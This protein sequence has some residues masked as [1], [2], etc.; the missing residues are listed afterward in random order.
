MTVDYDGELVNRIRDGDLLVRADPER[1]DELLTAKGT[2]QAE[3]GDGRVMNKG[4][5]AV[6]EEAIASDENFDFWI[7]V[8]LEY[9]DK[10]TGALSRGRKQKGAR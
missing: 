4:W 7:G 2:R 6:G 9:N 5:I 10:E 8:A 3:M 1:A